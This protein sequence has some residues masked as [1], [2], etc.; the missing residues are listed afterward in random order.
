MIKDIYT[1]E[2]QV[3]RSESLY[4]KRFVLLAEGTLR[5]GDWDLWGI[6]LVTAQQRVGPDIRY[7]VTCEHPNRHVSRV[8][9]GIT[10]SVSVTYLGLD[11]LRRSTQPKGKL[12]LTDNN[13]ELQEVESLHTV[14]LPP[15]PYNVFSH[16]DQK[17]VWRRAGKKNQHKSSWWRPWQTNE[18]G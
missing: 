12:S 15:N 14:C 3:L 17:E 11:R 6:P 16:D 4:R 9:N 7:T 8:V 1:I 13:L 10:A 5:I 18:L 2:T